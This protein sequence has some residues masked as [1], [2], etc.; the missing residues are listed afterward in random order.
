MGSARDHIEDFLAGASDPLGRLKDITREL[1]GLHYRLA[2][3]LEAE[4]L[5]KAKVYMESE[6]RTVSGREREAS[7]TAAPTTGDIILLKGEIAAY[8]E[9]RDYLRL[10]I[11]NA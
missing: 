3:L 11:Q 5:G 8:V 1:I 9:E 7:V 6:D 4:T 2:L 10:V